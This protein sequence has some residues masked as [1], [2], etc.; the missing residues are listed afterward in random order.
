MSQPS[1]HLL[2]SVTLSVCL[3]AG[4][5]LLIVPPSSQNQDGPTAP[6]T[7]EKPAEEVHKNIQVLKGLPESQL[8]PVMDY[9]GASLGVRCNFCHVNKDGNWDYAS[10]EKGAKKSAREMI[11]MVNGINKNS[12][13]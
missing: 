13:H 9:M 2:R 3:M 10:D 12:F 8:I 11:T 6:A 4:L 5:T 1:S 7:T